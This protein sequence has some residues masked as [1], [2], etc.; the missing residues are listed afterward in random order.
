MSNEKYPGLW[1]I[2]N[3]MTYLIDVIAKE[4]SIST[5]DASILVRD[6]VMSTPEFNR[7]KKV[8]EKKLKEASCT[9]S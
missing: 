7:I 6:A 3:H 1:S 4:F 8:V 9:P 5:K 2:T